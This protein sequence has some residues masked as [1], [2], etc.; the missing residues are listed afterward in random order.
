[1][2][3][4]DHPVRLKGLCAICGAD[5]TNYAEYFV[6][7]NL[8]LMFDVGHPYPLTKVIEFCMAALILQLVRLYPSFMRV[9]VL[10]R[11]SCCRKLGK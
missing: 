4:C 11:R 7:K 3:G 9:I 6:V 5:I 2:D 1:M 8:I 10:N